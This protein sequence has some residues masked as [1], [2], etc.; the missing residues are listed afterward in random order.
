MSVSAA[1]SIDVP[2]GQLFRLPAIGAS[3]PKTA[4]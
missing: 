3:T 2:G 4:R 1:T